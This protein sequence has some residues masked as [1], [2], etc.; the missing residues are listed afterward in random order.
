MALHATWPAGRARLRTPE[1]RRHGEIRRADDRSSRPPMPHGASTSPG[2][3]SAASGSRRRRESSR[4]RRCTDLQR[5][6]ASTQASYVSESGEA[7]AT[8]A[9]TTDRS[10]PTG[11]CYKQWSSPV[12]FANLAHPWSLGS[13]VLSRRWTDSANLDRGGTSGRLGLERRIACPGPQLLRVVVMGRRTNDVRLLNPRSRTL[14]RD[15]MI[16]AGGTAIRFACKDA[17]PECDARARSAQAVRPT[18]RSGAARRHDWHPRAGRRWVG[19]RSGREYR[20]S[21]ELIVTATAVGVFAIL[22]D[23]RHLLVGPQLH[24]PG[25]ASLRGR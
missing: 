12:R 1:C 15:A 21:L 23:W 5:A 16:G 7:S 24:R 10:P 4:L 6:Y 22:A 18:D 11:L 17:A 25:E 19:H 2:A 3:A 20:P 13:L 8:L 9:H 14:G